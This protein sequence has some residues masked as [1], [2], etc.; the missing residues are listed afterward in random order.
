MI[1]RLCGAGAAILLLASCKVDFRDRDEPVAASEISKIRVMESDRPL[2]AEATNV[3][4]DEISG[5]DTIQFIRFDL[6][7][8]RAESVMSDLTGLAIDELP[9]SSQQLRIIHDNAIDRSWWLERAV[10]GA[11]G[12][13]KGRCWPLAFMIVP[14]GGN[15]RIY[16][17]S[18]SC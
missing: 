11:R 9:A 7:K 14:E 8:A 17:S 5:I 18:G 12:A 6:P 15:S 10:P 2:P 1:A 4:Y 13:V 16:L 3:Y